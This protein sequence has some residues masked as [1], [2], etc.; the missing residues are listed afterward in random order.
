M[1]QKTDFIRIGTINVGTLNNKQE[2]VVQMMIDK[3]IAII[4]LAETRLKGKG[5]KI[6]HNNYELI[7]SGSQ[8]SKNSGVALIIEPSFAQHIEKTDAINER[9]LTVTLNIKGKR[10][11]FIQTY[12]PQQG[13]SQEEK[14]NFY[15]SLEKACDHLPM[16][17]DKVIMGDLNGHIG[18]IPVEGILGNFGIGIKNPE[19][20]ALIDFCTRNDFAIMNSFF[21]HQESHIYTWYRYNNQTENYDQ[22]SQIDFILSSNK[23]LFA[24]VKAIPS[25]SLDADHRLVVGKMKLHRLPKFKDNKRTRLCVENIITVGN[26][27][28]AAFKDRLSQNSNMGNIDDNIEEKWNRIKEI[29]LHVQN[30]IIGVKTTGQGKKKKTAWW[31]N[32]LQ[33]LVRQKQKAF[34]NWLKHRDRESR[35]KYTCMRNKVNSLKKRAKAEMWEKIGEDLKNDFEGTKKLMYSMAKKYRNGE[36]Q[37]TTHIKDKNGNMIANKEHINQRWNEYF[38][39]LLNVQATCIDNGTTQASN[40]DSNEEDMGEINMEELS[41]AMADTK[42]N[43]SCGPDDIMTETL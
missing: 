39:E 14:N 40:N 28:E 13:K 25:V 6:I 17:C 41:K 29:T 21:K 12:A 19:G 7:Y 4:G 31:T 22:K 43:K 8:N 42:K 38:D 10:T 18:A 26:E 11:S 5:R 2:E 30:S 15:E 36:K 32:E 9:I 37:F 34:Q 20:A 3:N 33:E 27:I 35:A 1:K 16:D 24:D 23:A